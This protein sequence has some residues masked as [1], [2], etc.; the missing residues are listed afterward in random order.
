VTAVTSISVGIPAYNEARYIGEAIKS[1]LNQRR[2][3]DEILVFDNA[4][5]D[6]TDQ[7]AAA[8][9]PA[10]AV[11]RAQE[12]MGAVENFNRAV[13]DSSGEYFA[14]LGADDAFFPDFL[15]KTAEL[16][17]T[18]PEVDA[19]FAYVEYFDNDGKVLY[20]DRTRAL[21]DPSLRRRVRS[22]IRRVR[23]CEVY[24]LYRRE[25]LLASPLFPSA[26]G[27]DVL[28]GWWFVLRGTIRVVEEP[29]IRKRVDDRDRSD[30]A[31]MKSLGAVTS[32][33]RRGHRAALWRALWRG[34]A[35][36]GIPREATRIARQELLLAAI[37]RSWLQSFVADYLSIESQARIKRA[38][39]RILGRPLERST[40]LKHKVEDPYQARDRL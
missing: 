34:A 12:N 16:L 26:Y 13:R 39:E 19:A 14:W 20:Y 8:L 38:I 21:N 5:T 37:G 30:D 7:V 2:P 10:D 28:L 25:A 29:L 1:V 33:R 22:Y 31:M 11:R 35:R 23:W 9:L 18:R 15:A 17:D 24:S 4:S 40:P 32:R 27:G 3:A 6:G 36:E